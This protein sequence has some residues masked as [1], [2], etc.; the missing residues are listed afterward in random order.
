MVKRAQRLCGRHGGR[1]GGRTGGRGGGETKPLCSLPVPVLAVMPAVP[2]C[3]PPA[4]PTTAG[5]I[6]GVGWTGDRVTGRRTHYPVVVGSRRW[7]RDW[8]GDMIRAAAARAVTALCRNTPPRFAHTAA[9]IATYRGAAT[10]CRLDVR[11]AGGQH[12][13]GVTVPGRLR[14]HTRRA[15][16]HRTTPP[17][18]APPAW[19]CHGHRPYHHRRAD[20]RCSD[21]TTK[22]REAM[23]VLLPSVFTRRMALRP[24]TPVVALHPTIP[25]RAHAPHT[26]PHT[27]TIGTPHPTPPVPPPPTPHLAYP[28][29]PPPPPPPPHCP[30]PL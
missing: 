13:G 26:A 12:H 8:S 15:T 3:L 16:P 11:Q 1:T 29:P 5:Y 23:V 6:T 2:T 9:Q 14:E 27:R 4:T 21:T 22:R 25:T 7:V 30:F 24:T 19:A 10:C 28:T 17:P 18:A 20:G